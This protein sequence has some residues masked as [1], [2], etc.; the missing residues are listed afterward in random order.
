MIQRLLRGWW[1][2]V[3]LG[4]LTLV[5]YLHAISLSSVKRVKSPLPAPEVHASHRAEE[6]WPSPSDLTALQQ[7]V[8]HEP[9]L[10]ASLIVLGVLM[11]VMVLGGLGLTVRALL[12]RRIWTLWQ[13]RTRQIP[14]WSFGELG[15][16]VLLV[17]LV[18]SLFPFIRMGVLCIRLDWALHSRA[19]VA[20]VMLLLDLFVVLT[21]LTV[22]SGKGRSISRVFG[23]SARTLWMSI[24][25]GLHGYVAV[26]PWLLVLLVLV[27][28]IARCVGVEPPPEPIQELIFEEQSPSILWL[29]VLLACVVGPLA[30]EL[31]FRGVLYAA[32]RRRTS[33]IWATLLSG[34]LFSLVHTNIVGFVPILL[35]G[36]VLADRYERTGSLMAPLTVHIAHNSLLMSLA[37]IMRHAAHAS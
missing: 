14:S 17:A 20:V 3:F 22:A 15:R 26:F 11:L 37:L 36:C 16:I 9:W 18:A 28:S 34:G 12:T 24:R 10:G 1:L 5:L 8:K 30:E 21:I 35:L 2:Y 33:R 31:F 27:V 32:L 23:V 25:S 19:W 7:T 6:W 29:T 13:G 4:V